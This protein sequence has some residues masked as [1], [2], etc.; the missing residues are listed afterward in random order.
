M[1][2]SIGFL[3]GVRSENFDNVRN[4]FEIKGLLII[5]TRRLASRGNG[6]KGNFASRPGN[7]N[8]PRRVRRRLFQERRG[9]V[10]SISG[11]NL[12]LRQGDVASPFVAE[13]RVRGR[14]CGQS[15]RCRRTTT[16]PTPFAW[17]IYGKN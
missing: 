16:L 8:S 4:S 7:P 17:R 12:F 3:R 11:L 9:G 6:T 5:R 15:S 1:L 14:V 10:C 2:G 13:G